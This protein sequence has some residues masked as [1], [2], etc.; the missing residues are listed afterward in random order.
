MLGCDNSFLTTGVW[1]AGEAEQGEGTRKRKEAEGEK[2][3]FRGK[4]KLKNFFQT[5]KII[6]EHYEQ[7]VTGNKIYLN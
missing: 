5:K 6:L 2:W 1:P 7:L 3:K 4:R